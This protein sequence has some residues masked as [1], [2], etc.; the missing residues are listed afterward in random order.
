MNIYK[1]I[2][3]FDVDL[4]GDKPNNCYS[5]P[6][7]ALL[8]RLIKVDIGLKV[9][10]KRLAE[11]RISFGAPVARAVFR[12]PE[13][14]S[15]GLP[16]HVSCRCLLTFQSAHFRLISFR[17]KDLSYKK[18]P[19]HLFI[20]SKYIKRIKILF[21]FSQALPPHFLC[22]QTMCKVKHCA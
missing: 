6:I 15:T 21:F 9:E 2:T 16:S 18:M 22:V 10:K 1:R 14:A 13:C 7:V 12:M 11:Y 19:V 5:P 17:C 4:G 8:G 20:F 3:D